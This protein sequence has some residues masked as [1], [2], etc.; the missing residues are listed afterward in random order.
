MNRQDRQAQFARALAELRALVLRGGFAAGERV[1]ETALAERFNLSRTPLRQ[2]MDRLIDEGLLERL[3]TGGC[4]IAR[5]ALSDV[6]D[7]IELRGM[8]EGTAA[9]LAAERGISAAQSAEVAALLEELDVAV[10]GELDFD[11][12]VRLNRA[13]HDWLAQAPASPIV[14]REV[15][16]ISRLPAASPTAF[17][18]G[19]DMVPDFRDSLRRAQVQHRAMVEAIEV[20][21]GARAESLAREHAR[22]ARLNLEYVLS[23]QPDRVEQ[24]PGLSLVAR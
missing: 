1:T 14:A 24:V 3:P 6:Q 22:L 18:Q 21:E 10:S 13:F 19:Q 5:F 12:Y 11:A 17:L 4:R 15:D 16:R 2:A 23:E 9:R 7:A 8:M 20:R